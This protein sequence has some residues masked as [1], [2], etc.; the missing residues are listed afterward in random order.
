MEKKA[1]P[2]NVDDYLK[3]FTGQQRETLE[4]IRSTIKAA[5]PNA[6]EVI[7][8]GMPAYRKNGMVGYFAGFKNHCSYFPG[9]YAVMKQFKEELKPYNVSKGTIQFPIDKPL[10]SSLLKKLV[11]AKIKENETKQTA[12]AAKKSITK[13]KTAKAIK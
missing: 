8:Y 4:N 12:K 11:I 2:K 13:K 10:S 1:P 6:E 7:S 5:A 3:S 9:S